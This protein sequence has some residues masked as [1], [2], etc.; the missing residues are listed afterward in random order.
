M[1]AVHTKHRIVSIVAIGVMNHAVLQKHCRT[2][3]LLHHPLS[4]ARPQL[5]SS[6]PGALAPGSAEVQ[7][8]I[9]GAYNPWYP[10]AAVPVN[11][12]ISLPMQTWHLTHT[13][14]HPVPTATHRGTSQTLSVDIHQIHRLRVSLTPRTQMALML[15]SMDKHRWE[16]P[17]LFHGRAPPLRALP[18]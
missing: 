2:P 11:H 12:E 17:V 5:I 18:H 7:P 3:I 14:P 1:A 9:L 16:R 10:Q 8:G 15:I 13:L 4:S 6:H